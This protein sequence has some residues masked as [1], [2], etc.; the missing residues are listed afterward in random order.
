MKWIEI[1]SNL[2]TTFGVFLLV[3]QL[4][5]NRIIE[6]KR[7]EEGIEKEYREIVGK[8]PYDVFIGKDC[9][10]TDDLKNSLYRYI[11]LTNSQIDLRNNKAISDETW[12]DWVQ[13]IVSN[14]HLPTINKFFFGLLNE[15]NKIFIELQELLNKK[16]VKNQLRS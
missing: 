4:Y 9:T 10:L 11:D 8:I 16:R 3:Y 6:K 13:G 5:Q 7:F 12:K 2:A 14:F 15:N 1:A